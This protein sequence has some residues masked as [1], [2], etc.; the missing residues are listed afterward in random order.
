MPVHVCYPLVNLNF[1]TDRT[2]A[3]FAR[4]R[5][6]AYFTRMDGANKCGKTEAIRFSAIHNLPNVVSHIPSNQCLVLSKE[7]IPVFLEDALESDRAFLDS[8]H[9]RPGL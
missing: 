3:A 4:M 9:D 7:R 8:F 2:K 6:L 5:N 1:G